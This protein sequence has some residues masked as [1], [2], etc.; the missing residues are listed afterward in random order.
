MI[1]NREAF[2]N[3][4]FTL[5]DAKQLEFMLLV[6][7]GQLNVTANLIENTRM[8]TQV[9]TLA[10]NI[11][12]GLTFNPFLGGLEVQARI[13]EMLQAILAKMPAGLV[14]TDYQT[15]QYLWIPSN[16]NQPQNAT[17]LVNNTKALGNQMGM[18][19][20]VQAKVLS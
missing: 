17:A 20:K 19:N 2:T 11:L 4:T 12:S 14:L 13:A 6:L 18:L 5:P 15:A 3:G 1:L 7:D 16:T 10:A 9:L 8:D